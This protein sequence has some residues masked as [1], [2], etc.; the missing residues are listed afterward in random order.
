MKKSSTAFE[1]HIMIPRQYTCD[2]VNI[3]PPLDFEDIPAEAKELAL[4]V[5]DPDA[6]SKNF[7]HWVIYNM[8]VTSH[9]EENSVPGTQGIND[10]GKINYGGPCPPSGQHRFHFKLYAL[11]TNLG[12][13][14]GLSKAQL[15]M[16]MEGHIL[17]K[18]EFIGV[19]SRVPVSR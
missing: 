14:E 15:E 4:I 8:H 6:P 7:A 5:T 18:A 1:N 12:L 17:E 3:N 2:G 13:F 9:I 11:D 10:F 19:Y 16:V